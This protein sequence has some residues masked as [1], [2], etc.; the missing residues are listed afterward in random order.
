MSSTHPILE[1]VSS[2]GGQCRDSEEKEGGVKED[3]GYR[4]I[5]SASATR[6]NLMHSLRC[7][8]GFC[9]GA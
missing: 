1:N 5:G 3:K 6:G 4:R 8:A 2:D 9:S 7:F